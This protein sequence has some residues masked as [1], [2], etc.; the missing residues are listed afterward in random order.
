[1]RTTATPAR[2]TFNSSPSW[3]SPWCRGA[4]FTG[5]WPTPTRRP[6]LV[7][8][9]RVNVAVR[10]LP[11]VRAQLPGVPVIFDT[12]DLH[13]RRFG[14]EAALRRDPSASLRALAVKVEELEMARASD[15]VWV[16]S[17]DERQALLAE[18]PRL[19][20]EVLSLI[21][22][23][24]SERIGYEAREGLGFVGGFQHAP[25]V[26]AVRFLVERIMPR[27]WA[28]RADVVL[29]VVGADMPAEVRALEGPGVRILGHQR[30]LAAAPGR[31]ARVRGANP[32]RR[33]REGKIT[34]AL[35][36]GLPAV[37]T[38]VGAEGIGLRHDEEVLIAD[39]PETFAAAALELYENRERWERLS[40]AGQA[41]MR[42][43]FSFEAARA[44]IGED[45][46][47]LSVG[48][49]AARARRP[50]TRHTEDAPC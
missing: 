31:V 9:A 49:R 18:D 24:P 5:I 20:V 4:S 1:M 28:A 48:V 22:E 43:R 2:I 40:Q 6:D 21:H 23:I 10:V 19:S 17:E 30:D 36:F 3:T 29:A 47:A 27:I 16:V 44:R 39:T 11:I 32:L 50:V 25:N 26:D 35:S 38:W 33:R 45:L 8:I 15:L 12:V 41:G 13:Y 14:R 46:A 37:T 7:I 42:A 34:Q